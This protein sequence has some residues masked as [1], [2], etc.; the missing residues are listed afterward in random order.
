M[1]STAHVIRKDTVVPG[2]MLGDI[3]DELRLSAR[4]CRERSGKGRPDSDAVR[5][6]RERAQLLNAL[7]ARIEAL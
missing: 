2:N 3:L 5:A 7:I 6:Y 4:D 1:P